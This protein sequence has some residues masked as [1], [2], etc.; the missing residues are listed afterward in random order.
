MILGTQRYGFA[1]FIYF[2]LF[3][4][5]VLLCMLYLLTVVIHRSDV[6]VELL[7][8]VSLQTSPWGGSVTYM[9]VGYNYTVNASPFFQYIW[10]MAKAD[11]FQ[12]FLCYI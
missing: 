2:I 6:F 12:T 5:L 11:Y 10:L 4:G 3:F 7:K 8:N 9:K 1:A